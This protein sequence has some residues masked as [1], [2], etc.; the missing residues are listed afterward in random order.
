MAETTE[1]RAELKEKLV[2]I[3]SAHIR[4]EGLGKLRARNVTKE[5]GCALGALYNVFSD[6]DDLV[7][8]VNSRTLARLSEAVGSAN[9]GISE[10]RA[11]LVGLAVSYLDFA[12]AEPKLWMSLFEHRMPAGT[13]VPDWHLQEHAALIH[14]IAEPLGALQP[15][16]SQEKLAIR[17]KT[18][19]SAV[20][21]VVSMGLG[22]W[23]AGPGTSA[24]EAELRLLVNAMVSGLR[25]HGTS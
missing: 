5:A 23:F 10:P 8:H 19:F 4:A 24:V 9:E 13:A 17:A 22:E 15:H 25:G 20:H 11:R 16:L 14:Q 7:V 21:G 12:R 2:S 18:L 3:A 1:R 6:I